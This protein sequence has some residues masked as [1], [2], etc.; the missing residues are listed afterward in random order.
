M[1]SSLK[2][3]NPQSLPDAGKLGYSQ[4]SIADPSRLAFVSGQVAWRAEGG[5]APRTLEEQ[6][7]VVIENLKGALTA[8]ETSSQDIVQ[9]RVY[10]T[11]LHAE[12]MEVAMTQVM[13]FLDGAQPSL[14]GVGVAALAAPELQIEIEIVIQLPL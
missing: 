1:S 11:D 2:R 3:M 14:T 8:T 5:T 12:S 13:A 7:A 10:M 9:M 4:I 6:T